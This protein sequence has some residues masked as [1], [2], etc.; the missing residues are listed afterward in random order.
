LSIRDLLV[1]FHLLLQSNLLVFYFIV[2]F[3][4]K[5]DLRA[6][7]DLAE[8]LSTLLML[9]AILLLLLLEE[10]TVHFALRSHFRL[11]LLFHLIPLVIQAL[12][13]CNNCSFG[14]RFLLLE[15]LRG[16]ACQ[17]IALV[18]GI[19]LDSLQLSGFLLFQALLRGSDLLL[20]HAFTQRHI[21]DLRLGFLRR[22]LNLSFFRRLFGL[23][24]VLGPF[25]LLL[26]LLFALLFIFFAL[27]FLL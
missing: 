3:L 4:F 2:P 24:P 9:H 14:L 15:L 17:L 25:S 27:L 13:S 8:L 1:R 20:R 18:Q 19:R 7:F 23:L 22:G 11:H 16:A 21:D 6:L 5:H 10:L 12:L 26:P